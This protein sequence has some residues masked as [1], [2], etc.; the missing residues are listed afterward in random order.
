MDAHG[1][2]LPPPAFMADEEIR[3]FDDMV[4]KFFDRHAPPER[5]EAWREDGLV[6]REFWHEAGRAGLLGVS[7]PAEYGGGG[8]DVRHDVVIFEQ[9]VKKQVAGFAVALHNGIV[10]PYVVAHGTE[11]QKQRWLPRLSNGELIA[12]VAMSEPSVGSDLQNISTRAIRDG[13]GYRIQGAKT[14]ISSGILGNFIVVAAKTDPAQGAKGVS[15]LVVETDGAEGFRRG[16]KLKKVGLDAS[17]T[18]ELFFDDVRVPAD[19]LLGGVEGQGF[20]QLMT[21][22]PRE[23]LMIAV[24]AINSIELAMSITLDY[25]KQRKAFG[26]PI[27]D[28]QNTQFKLADLRTEATSAR[29]FVNHCIGELLADRLDG[30]TAAMAKLLTTELQ[31]RVV[32]QCLQFHGGYGYIDEYPISRL[33]RDARISRIYGG[34]N[35]IMRMLIARSL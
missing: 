17:D 33:Y 20:R 30:T 4:A 6:E 7:V 25:V 19:N 28:F 26:R 1:L 13:D 24:Q 14:F 18:A 34:S 11:A 10:V 5:V 27:L 31:G 32:D 15:L 16:R 9:Y 21:E 2:N 29:I 8:G 3:M 22:L 23:R 35:E 12:A